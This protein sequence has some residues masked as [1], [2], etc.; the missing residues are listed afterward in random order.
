M[1]CTST[2]NAY[3]HSP[4]NTS[5]LWSEQ[6]AVNRFLAYSPRP[7]RNTPQA[8]FSPRLL[9]PVGWSEK[10]SDWFV[11]FTH[12]DTPQVRPVRPS[13]LCPSEWTSERR[14]R[15][16]LLLGSRVHRDN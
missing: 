12:H 1:G 13:S 7:P 8:T 15:I 16:G 10:T 6:E 3:K 11:P 5:S 4:Q 2:E 9:V 14:H